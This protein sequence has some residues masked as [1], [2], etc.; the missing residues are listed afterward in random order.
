M[1]TFGMFMAGAF[2]MTLKHSAESKANNFLVRD[3]G[4]MK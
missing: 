2:Q 1:S 3:W 4:V